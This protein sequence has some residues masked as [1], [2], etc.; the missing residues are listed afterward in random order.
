MSRREIT[1]LSDGLTVTWT[2]EE[3]LAVEQSL[4]MQMIEHVKELLCTLWKQSRI[5]REA[6]T[7][8]E[9]ALSAAYHA[10]E[11]PDL[12][13]IGMRDGSALSAQ[14]WWKSREGQDNEF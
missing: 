4:D 6:R 10:V 11:R 7:A 13:N 9:N 3:A 2:P 1:R 12:K 14:Q 5:T 8:G